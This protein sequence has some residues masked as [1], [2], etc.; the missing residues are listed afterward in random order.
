[1][2]RLH[3]F[4]VDRIKVDRSFVSSLTV[5]SEHGSIADAIIALGQCLGLD[6]VAEGV[7]SHEQLVALRNL[8]CGVAQ[9][10]FLSKPVAPQEIE[11]LMGAGGVLV[12]PTSPDTFVGDVM[13]SSMRQQDRLVRNLLAEL[14]R[15]TGLESTYLTRID[16]AAGVQEVTHALNTGA[17]DIAEELS[18]DWSDALCRLALDDLPRDVVNG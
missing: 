17:M 12:P 7:E 4:R 6:V 10:Y 16:W 2:S 8:G 18:A 9:G 11:R 1:V 14:Q 5:G 13:E 15:L 3:T